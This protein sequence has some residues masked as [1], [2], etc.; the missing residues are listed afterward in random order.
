MGIGLKLSGS[1]ESCCGSS[2]ARGYWAQVVWL[3]TGIGLKWSGC[4]G[5]VLQ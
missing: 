4:L 2:V 5:V 3:L 1:W